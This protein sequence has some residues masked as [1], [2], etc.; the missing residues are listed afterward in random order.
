MAYTTQSALHLALW[1]G[2]SE[3]EVEAVI[4]FDVSWAVAATLESPAEPAMAEVLDFRIRKPKTGEWLA[5][6][7]WISDAFEGD[8]SFMDWLVSEATD[9]EEAA[10]DAMAERRSEERR[11]GR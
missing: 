1:E 2:G 8:E 5:C 9:Q 3:V 11:R 10:K 4:K 6:P 7:A